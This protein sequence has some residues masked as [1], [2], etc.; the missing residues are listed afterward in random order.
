MRTPEQHPDKESWAEFAGMDEID[1][2]IIV[3]APVVSTLIKY[4][5]WFDNTVPNWVFDFVLPLVLVIAAY[6]VRSAQGARKERLLR[7]KRWPPAVDESTA[8][9]KDE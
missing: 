8:P 6:K 3:L 1:L 2:V 5:H 7:A 9:G 4:Q